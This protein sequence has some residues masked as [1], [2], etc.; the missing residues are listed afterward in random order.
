MATTP[1]IFRVDADELAPDD[2]GLAINEFAG[3][4]I[5]LD[6]E[7][8]PAHERSL[9]WRITNLSRSSYVMAVEAEPREDAVDIGPAVAAALVDGFPEIQEGKRPES[10]SDEALEH[11]RRLSALISDGVRGVTVNAPMIPRSATITKETAARIEAVIGQGYTSIGAIE[12]S[13]EGIS[14]H[15]QPSFTVYD[16]VTGRAVRCDFKESMRQ[17]VIEALG[18]K[19]IV[20]GS[21]RRDP[22]GRATRVR[23]V[24]EF[25]RL[26]MAPAVP[27]ERLEGMFKGLNRDSR[28]YLAEIR[29]E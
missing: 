17:Q 3:L 15:G 14:I 11:V 29:G 25:R 24:D 20:H 9:Q 4:L 13:L 5:D 23:E 22:L 27:L 28:D 26:G 12:G 8:S 7:L 10:Y 2:F 6:R 16:A 18:H 1:L 19:V 21:I